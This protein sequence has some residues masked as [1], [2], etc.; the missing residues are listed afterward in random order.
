MED[1]IAS[2]EYDW[3]DILSNIHMWVKDAQHVTARQIEAISNIENSI[4]E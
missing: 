3:A 1:L 2:G 4:H